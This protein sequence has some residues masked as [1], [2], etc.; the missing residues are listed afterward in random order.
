[1]KVTLKQRTLT[2]R[3][4]AGERAFKSESEVWHKLKKE[5]IAKGFDCIKKLMWKDGHMFGDQ[6]T[7][8]VRTRKPPMEN[9]KPRRD[10]FMVYDN[11]YA[12]RLLHKELNTERH[13][14]LAV[15]RGGP[16]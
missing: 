4:E 15:A 9:E 5:L 10:R 1:M 13:V 3:R 8:Y 6:R 16:G 7:H 11:N 2:I 14:E 12:I